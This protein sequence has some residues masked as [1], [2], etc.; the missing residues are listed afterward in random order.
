MIL[1]LQNRFSV[2]DFAWNFANV[3]IIPI[4]IWVFW[5]I[6]MTSQCIRTSKLIN[7]LVSDR[8]M[9]SYHRY[10]GPI[11]QY[12]SQS[13][14]SDGA[15]TNWYFREVCS[16]QHPKKIS[17]WIEATFF[18]RK[19]IWIHANPFTE[20]GDIFPAGASV[21]WGGVPSSNPRTL[22]NYQSTWRNASFVS[23]HCG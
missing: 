16:S 13:D 9:C 4:M 7:T 8:N 23:A 2:S 3:S 21:C 12:S 20:L 19:R 18:G 10:D 15:A 6:E 11:D 14:F 5:V 22:V 1:T 17:R